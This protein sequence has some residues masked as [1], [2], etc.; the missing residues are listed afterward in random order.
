MFSTLPVKLFL[1]CLC[2]A[3]PAAAQ[4]D[5]PA[6][7]AKFGAPLNRETFHMPAGFDLVADYGASQQVCKLQTPALMPTTENPASLTVMN[8]RMYAFLLE[9]V[10]DSMRGKLIGS[11]VTQSGM[12]SMKMTDYEHIAIAETSNGT[13]P[14]SGTIALTFKGGDCQSAQ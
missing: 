5:S 9:L 8:R 13:N 2:C 1:V 10:P 11:F 7:R 4:L 6:L 3:A 12:N 14:Y